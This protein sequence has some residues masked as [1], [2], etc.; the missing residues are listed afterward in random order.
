LRTITLQF[1]SSLVSLA[2]NPY[3]KK[4]F[5]N[6]VRPYIDNDLDYCIIFPEHI[7]Y[8]ASSFV[9]GF[10]GYWIE[11]IGVDGIVR[12]IDIKSNHPELKDSIIKRL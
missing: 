9:Q 12:H 10:F 6:Q 5:D 1:D 11:S 3:G 8:V 4:E 2:G 7:K